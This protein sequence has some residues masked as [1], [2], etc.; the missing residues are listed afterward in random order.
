MRD[1]GTDPDD[2]AIATAIVQMAHSLG[3]STIAE[4][5]AT[6]EQLDYLRAQGCD[7]VQGYHY[8]RPLLP[9]HLET[10][11]RANLQ[12]RNQTP[13]HA[14]QAQPQA[15]VRARLLENAI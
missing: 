3:M 1:I 14:A 5:V 10:F 15:N 12:A 9:D 6:A 4:G 11:V 2:Q 13:T 8:S 7:Q